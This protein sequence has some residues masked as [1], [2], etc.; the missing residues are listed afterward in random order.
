MERPFEIEI[1]RLR[2]DDSLANLTVLLNRAYR[3]LADM[4]L[5]FV[6]ATQ[7]E[8]RTR[9]RVRNGMCF[10]A[11]AGGEPVGTLTYYPPS[12]TY[13]SRW[14]DRPEVA[15]VKQFAVAPAH[16]GK[17]IGNR[18]LETAESTA[19]ISGATELALDTAQRATH[20]VAYYGR[21]G[22]RVIE[23]VRWPEVNYDSFVM[24]KRLVG[25]T[26]STG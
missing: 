1:R 18:L 8:R 3:S 4:G 19:R 13:G 10:L 17:G 23:A 5:H 6:A 25:E 11:M 24:S 26:R 2:G 15:S 14:L 16:Q 7:D 20:L 12:A 21:H 22:Y 9:E